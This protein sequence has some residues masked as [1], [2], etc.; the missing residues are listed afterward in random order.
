MYLGKALGGGMLP[1]SAVVADEPIL[2]VFTPDSHSSTFGG[3]PLAAAVE[4]AALDV[5]DEKRLAERA[6]E[7]GEVVRA[8][9]RKIPSARLHQVRGKGLLNAMVFDEGFDAEAVCM[10][11]KDEGILAKQTHGNIIRL[12]PPLVI[13]REDLEAALEKIARTVARF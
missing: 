2:G 7:L 1:I 4:I 10:A 8:R 3:N 13:S 6:A 9:L 5:L 12:A 11:L